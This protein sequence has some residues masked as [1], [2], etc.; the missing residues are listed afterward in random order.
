MI[1]TAPRFVVGSSANQI[2]QLQGPNS[3]PG[4]AL[5]LSKQEIVLSLGCRVSVINLDLQLHADLHMR[6]GS[7]SATTAQIRALWTYM[8]MGLV[9]FSSQVLLPKDARMLFTP[10]PGTST[11]SIT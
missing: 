8:V 2:A 3:I 4:R 9:P 11:L 1:G 5:L 7:T 10:N 6:R